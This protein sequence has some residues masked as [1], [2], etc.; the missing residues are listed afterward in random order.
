MQTPTV[1]CKEAIRARDDLNFFIEWVGGFSVANPYH[2]L[3]STVWAT[4]NSNSL[5]N[6][7]AG[8]NYNILAP[9]GSAKSTRV[10]FAVAWAIGHNPGI[11]ILYISYKQSIALS[12]SR[13]IKRIIENPKYREVFPHIRPNKNKWNDTEWEIDKQYAGIS[14]LEYDYTLYAVGISGGIVSKRSWLIVIDDAIKN[15]TSILNPDVRDKIRNNWR[16]AALPTLLGEGRIWGINTR[17]HKNDIHVTDLCPDKGI[18]QIEQ[19]AIIA[20]DDGFEESYWEEFYPFRT[21]LIE[22]ADG[23]VEEVKGLYEKREEDPVTF[24]FQMQ[25][26]IVSDYDVDISEDW[27]Q[28]SEDLPDIELFDEFAFGLDLAARE[29][30]R[31]DFTALTLIGKIGDALWVLDGDRGRWAGNLDKIERILTMCVDWQ[32]LRGVRDPETEQMIYQEIEDRYVLVHAEDIN[33][34]AS[35]QAD[36]VS[37]VQNELNIYTIRCLGAPAKGDKAQRLK[38]TTGKFQKKKIYFNTYRKRRL[39]ILVDE[40]V[41]FGSTSY[42]DFLDSFVYGISGIMKRG[43]LTFGE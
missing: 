43:S 14:N 13:L 27:I 5:L 38:A 25:N 32:L 36:W 34:Q 39:S 4:G 6:K 24:A 17:F 23:S 21:R 31:L 10:A 7:I 29:R 2:N 3:W 12:R 11:P 1:A 41:N 40:L 8:P 35:L 20:N 9:R 19:P 16:T 30:E 26:T 22:Y 37:T 42:D 15:R 28:W 18:I 33:Y